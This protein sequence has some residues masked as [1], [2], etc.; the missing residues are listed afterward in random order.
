WRFKTRALSCGRRSRV[1]LTPRR[2]CQV[3]GKRKLFRG[4]GGQKARAPGSARIIRKPLRGECRVIPVYPT[5][6]CAFLFY[7]AHAAIGRIGRPAFPAPSVWR[8]GDKWIAREK[9]IRRDRESVSQR[10]CEEPL[11]RSNPFFA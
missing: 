10:H 5:N 11:R 8:A 9:S 6:A 4:D 7:M 3:P 2:W 1:V